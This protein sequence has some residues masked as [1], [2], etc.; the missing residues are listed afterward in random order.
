YA[1]LYNYFKDIRDLIF[2]CIEDFMDEC[3]NFVLE[4]KTGISPGKEGLKATSQ[5][6]AKFFI[7]YPGIFK[8][9][10]EQNDI[11]SHASNFVK[12]DQFFKS[13]TDPDWNLLSQQHKST[14]SMEAREIH[15]LAIHGLLLFYLNQ[16][17][18]FDFHKLMQEIN[19]LTDFAL[20]GY[21]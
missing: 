1:T 17:K 12:I 9:L 7:Q 13:L 11:A 6:Y 2:C 18:T 3:H 16:R 5:N 15:N 19:N 8:L 14:A 20:I 4:Q 21:E 10:Y